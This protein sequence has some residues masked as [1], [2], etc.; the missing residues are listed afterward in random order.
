MSPER[1][2]EL[3]KYEPLIAKYRDINVDNQDWHEYVEEDWKDRLKERGIDMDKLYFSGF[4]CQGDGA[5]FEGRVAN[6]QAFMRA[7][8]MGAKYPMLNEAA[9]HISFCMASW[10][11]HGHYYHENCVR[12][13]HTDADWDD[14]LQHTYDT[15]MLEEMGEAIIDKCRAEMRGLEDDIESLVTDYC[16]EIYRA[17]EAEYEYL[18][19]DEAVFETLEANDMLTELEEDDEIDA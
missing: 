11:H 6:F 5:M 16:V 15:A 2:A 18:T 1:E 13:S 8:N 14:F 9:E 19:S 3:A 17:L 7:H 4:W 12:F 10:E